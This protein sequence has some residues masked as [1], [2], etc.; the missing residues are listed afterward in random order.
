MGAGV[1]HVEYDN[2]VFDFLGQLVSF[3]MYLTV[4]AVQVA[5]PYNF[6]FTSKEEKTSREQ[7]IRNIIT[8]IRKDKLDVL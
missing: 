5:F 2:K 1:T 6:G 4:S 8:E 7:I 3:S